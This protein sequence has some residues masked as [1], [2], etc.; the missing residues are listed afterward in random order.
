MLIHMKQ[1]ISPEM[2]G[3]AASDRNNEKSTFAEW[4]IVKLPYGLSCGSYHA[5]FQAMTD[6]MRQTYVAFLMIK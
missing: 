2:F 4:L 1:R 3:C 6:I 5:K